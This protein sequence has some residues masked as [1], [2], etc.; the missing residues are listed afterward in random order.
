MSRHL[1]RRNANPNEQS[2]LFDLRI[3]LLRRVQSPGATAIFPAAERA[4]AAGGSS[5]WQSVKQLGRGVLGRWI[6][7]LGGTLMAV[8]GLIADINQWTITPKIW[9]SLSGALFFWAIVD[10]FHT[11]RLE[12][13]AA[14]VMV[15]DQR[16]FR[17][18]ADTL[19]ARHHFGVHQLA[20]KAPRVGANRDEEFKKDFAIWY[21]GVKLW[22]Q[23]VADE[24]R[25]LGCTEQEFSRFWTI[26]ELKPVMMIRGDQWEQAVVL[27]ATRVQRLWTIIESYER[28]ADAQLRLGA[29]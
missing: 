1:V 19:T 20:N 10:A 28:R 21:D 6:Q 25:E 3:S 26:D 2:S 9:L 14:T 24:M 15:T 8:L 13:D 12:R 27:H 4:Q 18:I 22:N 5:R 29:G 17:S 16:H 23:T 11:V 7:S